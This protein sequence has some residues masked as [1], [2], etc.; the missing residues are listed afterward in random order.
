MSVGKTRDLNMGGKG[1]RNLSY[2]SI[3]DQVKFIDAIKFY[4]EPLH[5]LAASMGPTEYQNIKRS[6]I[7]FLETHPRFSFKYSTLTFENKKWVVDYLS[8]GKVVIPYEMIKQWENLNIAPTLNEISFA[9]TAFHSSLINSTIT[10]QEYEDVKKLFSFMKMSN[11]SDLNALFNFQYKRVSKVILKMDENN[12]YGNAM[13]KPFPIGCIKKEPQTPNIREL[14]LL[15][16]GLSHLDSIGHLFVVD[17]EFNVERATEKELFFNEIYTPLFEKKKVLPARDRSVFQFFDAIRLKD[18][19][20][21]NNYKCTAKTHS[22][23]D[24]KFLVPL[25]AEHFFPV[26]AGTLLLDSNQNS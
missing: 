14:C 5:A 10:D 15:L 26:F 9:K 8:G 21:S 16:S 13:T 17:L 3:A 18:N 7:M 23:M 25:Y 24:K 11:L 12:Q 19:T 2:A 1:I 4:Q 22:T 6:M 20:T